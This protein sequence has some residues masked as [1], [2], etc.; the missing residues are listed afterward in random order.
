MDKSTTLWHFFFP[1]IKHRILDQYYQS[2]YS[3]VNNAQRLASYSRVK[4]SFELDSYLN[5]L[6]ERKYKIAL[7]KF[8]LSSHNLEIERGRYFNVPRS[9]RI[10]KICQMNVIENEFHFRLTC[11]L[12]TDLRRKYFK[13]YYYRWPTLN[14]F[15]KLMTTTKK[16]WNVKSFKV[17]FFAFKLRNE[18]DN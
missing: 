13:P 12:Y 2:W 17:Y 6:S 16:N 11:P 1:E 18:N 4:H 9:E 3:E 8:R 7:S 14:K 10:C 5:T 15:D